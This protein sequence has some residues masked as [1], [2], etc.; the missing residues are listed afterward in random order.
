MPNQISKRCFDLFFSALVLIALS[1]LLVCISVLVKCSDWGP[2]F[3]RQRRVGQHGKLFWLWKFRTMIVNAEKL[4]L[5]LTKDGD[6]RI[7]SIGRFLRKSKLDDLPQLWNVLKGEMSFVGP[8]PEVPQFVERYTPE[9][10]EILAYKPGITGLATLTFRDEEVLLRNVKN[11]ESFYVQYCIPRKVTLDCQYAKK[12]NLLQDTWIILQALCPYWLAVVSIYVVVLA[13]SFWLA[14]L[15]RFGF[16]ATKWELK[17]AIYFLFSFVTVKLLLLLL[18]KEFKGLM[19]YFSV[20]ELQRI[21]TAL[22][23]ALLFQFGLWNLS[24]GV[25]APAPSIILIDFFISIILLCL[26]R[27]SFRLMRERYSTKNSVEENKLSPGRI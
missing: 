23:L 20:P 26:L 22:G 11:L 25:L 5:P 7:T 15:L 2:I 13:T 14:Y 3:F 9:Q 10:R 6:P 12:A 16:S 18:T 4:G 24:G 21:T 27:L 17:R 19:S 8:R 1:P